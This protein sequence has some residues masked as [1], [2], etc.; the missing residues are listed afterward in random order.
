MIKHV[1]KTI[2]ILDIYNLKSWASEEC[3]SVQETICNA[4][5]KYKFNT[6]VSLSIQYT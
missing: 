6:Y 5:Q 1:R 2:Q 3:L 4:I